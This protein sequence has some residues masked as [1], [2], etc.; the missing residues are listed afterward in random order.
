VLLG[1]ALLKAHLVASEPVL[2]TNPFHSR[3]FL[4]VAIW[5][6][7]LLASWMLA[8]MHR[9]VTRWVVIGCFSAFAVVALTLAL[10][11]AESCGCF[12]RV[13]VNP[14]YTSAFDSVIA[15]S[16]WLFPGS[17]SPSLTASN[18]PGRLISVLVAGPMLAGTLTVVMVRSKSSMLGD[19]GL[20]PDH[21]SVVLLEPETWIGKKFPLLQYIE[22]DSTSAD[23]SRGNWLVALYRHD[24]SH[25]QEV[26]PVLGA[27]AEE[28]S[29][30]P[31]AFVEVPPCSASS[32]PLVRDL[33]QGSGQLAIGR[34]S[35]THRWSV[36]TPSL[37]ELKNGVVRRKLNLP[38]PAGLERSAR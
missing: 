26:V 37:I 22:F 31:V 3:P 5:L 14:W 12:G 8:G 10:G 2:S 16:V 38:L 7:V 18:A 11:G 1:A 29:K 33:L 19:E 24:C 25:C 15:L 20:I 23:L 32:E 35:N 4:I 30:I 13:H 21:L 17:R 6:E 34:L 27:W 9:R 36:Q 28:K